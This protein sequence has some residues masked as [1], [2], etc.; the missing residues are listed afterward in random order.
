[1]GARS[2]SSAGRRPGGLAAWA[3]V[4]ALAAVWCGA[5]VGRGAD[6]PVYGCDEYDLDTAL[7]QGGYV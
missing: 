4:L 1:M 5:G 2:E 7:A 3:K 6:G